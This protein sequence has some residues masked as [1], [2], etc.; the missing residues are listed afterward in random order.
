[1]DT[2]TDT[3]RARRK[4]AGLHSRFSNPDY[5]FGPRA[6][7]SP[8]SPHPQKRKARIVEDETTDVD[9]E[10]ETPETPETPETRIAGIQGDGR[11]RAGPWKPPTCPD[12]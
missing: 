6:S 10:T 4:N 5:Q 9:L 12:K 3:T 1:M 11:L 2:G 8:H 7:Q